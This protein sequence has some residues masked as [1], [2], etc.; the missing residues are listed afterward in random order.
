MTVE[1]ERVVQIVFLKLFLP[2]R[3]ERTAGV[4]LLE[5]ATGKLSF[6]IRDDWDTIADAADAE[7]LS[8]VAEEFHNRLNELG[9]GSGAELLRSLEDQLSNVLRLSDRQRMTIRNI[10]ATLDLLFDQNCRN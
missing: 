1:A 10:G 8:A 3:P 6:R 9:E 7:I 5:E 4:F 2:G